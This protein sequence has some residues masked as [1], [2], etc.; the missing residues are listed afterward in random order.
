MQKGFKII[1]LKISNETHWRQG[2]VIYL[3][4]SLEK[5]HSGRKLERDM[6]HGCTVAAGGDV[7]TLFLN[8]NLFKI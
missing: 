5:T 7:C 4:D 6:D 2:S 3:E 8:I 1:T